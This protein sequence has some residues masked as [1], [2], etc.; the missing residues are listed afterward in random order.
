MHSTTFDYLKPSESQLKQM[1]R[2]RAA[3]GVLAGAIL[4]DVPEGRYRALA[5]TALEES[6]MWANKGIT[7]DS[8]GAPRDGATVP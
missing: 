7:R 6:A 3:Y 1:E 4:A 8:N 5:I 2:V